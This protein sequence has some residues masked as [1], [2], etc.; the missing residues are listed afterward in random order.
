MNA[1]WKPGGIAHREPFTAYVCDETT[2]EALRPIASELGWAVEKIHKGGL[3][4]GVQSLSITASPNIL[5]VDLS[6][7]GKD[8]WD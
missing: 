3:R 5:M 6:E 7:S 1:P 2:A 8:I 4:N